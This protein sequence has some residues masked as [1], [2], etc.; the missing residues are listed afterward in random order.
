MGNDIDDPG[1][2]LD[3]FMVGLEV[4]EWWE[5]ACTR[6]TTSESASDLASKDQH[7]VRPV[8]RQFQTV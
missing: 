8:D 4:W 6:L 3:D 1:K 7:K 2:I 5:L